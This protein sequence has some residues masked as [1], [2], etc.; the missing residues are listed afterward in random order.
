M[1]KITQIAI[2]TQTP[3]EFEGVR[4]VEQ[5]VVVTALCDDGTAWFI[6]P[7]SFEAKWDR[8]P[9]MPQDVIHLS[10]EEKQLL[11]SWK[12]NQ[13]QGQLWD[14]AG[15]SESQYKR[16]L[17]SVQEKLGATSIDVCIALARESKLLD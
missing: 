12:P 8:L 2:A 16:T 4:Q 9:D 14:N 15:L 11:L 10:D 3:I 7:D 13:L 5:E 1:R 17:K 6:R